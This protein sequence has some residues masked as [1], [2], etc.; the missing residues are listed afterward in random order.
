MENILSF[1]EF[2]N[3][4]SDKHHA[5]LAKTAIDQTGLLDLEKG[6]YIPKRR[7]RDTQVLLQKAKQ[8]IDK[9]NK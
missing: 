9:I 4:K 5:F 2:I 6:K 3:E 8:Q 1:E 7:M